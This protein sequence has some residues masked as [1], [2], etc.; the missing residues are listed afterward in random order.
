MEVPIFLVSSYL[1]Q[2]GVEFIPS[3]FLFFAAE[4]TSCF[5]SPS[6]GGVGLVSRTNNTG[7]VGITIASLPEGLFDGDYHALTTSMVGIFFP[8]AL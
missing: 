8:L 6:V 3:G 4:R 7:D 2:A 5:A 1:L